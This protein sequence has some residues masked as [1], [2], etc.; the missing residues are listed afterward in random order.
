MADRKITGHT[1]ITA[2]QVDTANDVIE[3]VDVSDTTDAASG[4]NKKMTG[5][6]LK[7][8]IPFIDKITGSTQNRYFPQSDYHSQ[9]TAALTINVLRASPYPIRFPMTI[10][11]LGV[12]VI[13]GTTG[14]IRI[15]IYDSDANGMPANLVVDSGEITIT[16]PA[17]YIVTV[18][19]TL[20]PGLYWWAYNT[21]T[22][23]TLRSTVVANL[24]FGCG[25]S[26]S[27]GGG[28]VGSIATIARTYQAL[29]ATFGAASFTNPVHPIIFYRIA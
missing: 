1:A 7:K 10:D 3:I 14:N 19:A 27:F 4:T 13:T 8:F 9:T 28:A 25:Y 18:S 2:A 26:S 11:R 21:D 16:A 12:E 22:G 17:V 23:N 24:Y 6:E 15:G 5:A 20:A 29:P